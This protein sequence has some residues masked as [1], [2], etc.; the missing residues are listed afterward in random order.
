LIE[1]P[2]FEAIDHCVGNQPDN[3]MEATA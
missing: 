3:E 1:R 2:V